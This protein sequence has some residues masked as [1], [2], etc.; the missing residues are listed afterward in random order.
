MKAEKRCLTKSD[1]ANLRKE[2]LDKP[3][4]KAHAVQP[5]LLVVNTFLLLLNS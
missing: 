4:L 5:S 2:Q 3:S 1:G